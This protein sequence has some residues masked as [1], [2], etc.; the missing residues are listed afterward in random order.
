MHSLDII[1]ENRHV[2]R[3][4]HSLRRLKAGCDILKPR[5]RR[6]KNR[7][8]GRIFSEMADILEFKGDNP[9]KIRAYRR[10][11]LNLESL[12]RG[13]EE[14]T[15][16]EL[17]EVPGIGAELA[18]KIE[19]YLKTGRVGAFE[20]MKEAIPPGLVTLLSIPGMGPKTALMLYEKLGIRTIDELDEAV[21][22]GRLDGLRGIKEK[23]V[24]NIRSGIES[25]RRGRERTPLSKALPLA[26]DLVEELKRRGPVGRIEIAGSIRRRCETVKDIDLLATST[27]PARLME[28][29]VD[30]PLA[31]RVLMNGSTRSSITV[32]EGLQVDLRVVE[33]SCFGSALAHLTGS[34]SHNVHLREMAVRRGL[35]INEY[36]IFREEDDFRLGG[37]NEEDLYRILEI[38]FIPPELREDRGEVEAA[39]AGELPQLV[40]CGDLKGDLHVHS[41][42]SDGAHS[43]EELADAARRCGLSYIA[44]TDHSRELGIARG[45]TPERLMEQKRE[46][47]AVNARLEG[48]TILHG[49]E[50]D[51]R[52]DGMLD[53]PDEV[54]KELDVVIASVHSGFRQPKER[55][56]ARIAAAMRNP[57]VSII[58]HPTG[59]LLGERE[60]YEI[61][62]EEL[63][64]TARDTGTAMEINSY[65]QRLDLCDLHARRAKELGV[66]VTIS[67]DSHTVSQFETL[68]WGVAVARRAWLSQQDVLNTLDAKALL[69]RLHRKRRG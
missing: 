4:R 41:R 23:S 38:P 59:R 24:E 52:G 64:L 58:G 47:A 57:F 25:V 7:E 13:V 29:F 1:R 34:R 17:R 21:R 19:E 65:P 46:V 35:K 68:T 51:I 2:S 32:R 53:F 8:I 69:A 55:V 36:G 3:R 45:L 26:R 56:M 15:P 16:D 12:P 5:G 67:S 40:E 50:M 14:L 61:D 39:L 11:A 28:V 54:L 33:E 20:R 43:L 6:M 62:M 66:A 31:D 37:A 9:F 27:D 10:A 48:F 42:W 30:L 22:N 60:P 63:L 44:L 18:S 49:T